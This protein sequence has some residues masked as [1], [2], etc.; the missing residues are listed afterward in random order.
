MARQAVVE[1]RTGETSV[2]VALALDGKGQ[3]EISTGV[4]FLDHML[5]ALARHGLFDLAVEATGDLVVDE[6]HTAE[7][8]AIVLGR[9]FH[10]ALG[11]RRGI[12]RMAHAIVPL[13]EALALVAVDIGG[14]SYA[15]FEADFAASRIGTLEADLVRH[16]FETLATEGRMNIHAHLLAGTNDHHKA[17][18]LFKALARALDAATRLDERLGGE[19]PSTKGTLS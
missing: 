7:D 18:A 6:H 5:N 13:D 11:D 3:A 1:R 19:V 15:V 2:R 17:E 14:R 16:F 9:A 4:G 8:V 12:R 10:E